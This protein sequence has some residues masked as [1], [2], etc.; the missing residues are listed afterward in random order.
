[1]AN[2]TDRPPKFQEYVGQLTDNQRAP[3][4]WESYS[5]VDEIA[6]L[7][8]AAYRYTE[9]AELLRTHYLDPLARRVL[10]AHYKRGY[11]PQNV[12]ADDLVSE[13]WIKLFDQGRLRYRQFLGLSGLSFWLR[14][15]CARTLSDLI[16]R[17]NP[18]G[19]KQ[20]AKSTNGA[21]AASRNLPPDDEVAWREAGERIT[22]QYLRLSLE[23]RVIIKLR[24]DGI[25]SNEVI[26]ELI[27][28]ALG[29]A[30]SRKWTAAS[31]SRRW[32]ELC[33]EFQTSLQK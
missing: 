27:N 24:Q 17:Q 7:V 30:A 28:L 9:A 22:Q 32:N 12:T 15:V 25:L 16:R 19:K 3:S 33:R 18:S 8:L 5:L 2:V 29:D 6:V 20:N 11:P 13:V 26:A 10:S 23:D 4:G 1:M 14:A 21:N 31:V